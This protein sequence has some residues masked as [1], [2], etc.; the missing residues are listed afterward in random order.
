MET[1]DEVV[2]RVVFT[3]IIREMET[4]SGSDERRRNPP[5]RIEEMKREELVSALEVIL[6]ALLPLPVACA[7]KKSYDDLL[8]AL[9]MKN[10]AK[11]MIHEFAV[12]YTE[13]ILGNQKNA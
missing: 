13:F 7:G 12:K 3:K 10:K 11:E 8:L 4:M 6:L 1:I 9:A 2:M 5:K